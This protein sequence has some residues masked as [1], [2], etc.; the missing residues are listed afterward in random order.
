VPKREITIEQL[1]G[2]I[3]A[4]DAFN[5]LYQF[6]SNVRQLD[7]TPLMDNKG[8]VTS[9]LSGLFYRTT[10][11]MSRGIKMIY[12]FDGISPELKEKTKESREERKEDAREKYNDALKEGSKE[13]MF[14]YSRQNLR[15]NSEMIEESKALIRALGLPVVQAPSEGEAQCAHIVKMSEAYAV[16]SQDYDALAFGG[17]RLIQNL[18]LAKKRRLANGNFVPVSPEMIELED[19]FNSLQINHDQLICLGILIGTDFN[20]GGIKG[21]GPKKALQLVQKYPQP[22]LLFNEVRSLIS[23]GKISDMNFNWQDIFELFK[24][25]NITEDYKLNFS[26][27]DEE[28]VKKILCDEHDFSTERA[29][30]A[31]NK[32]FEQKDKLSQKDLKS[33]F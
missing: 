29:D 11:L 27:I 13:D 28:K 30:S 23:Q 32:I 33:F 8:R 22:V 31:L 19:L 20:P 5:T 6:L 16:A 12:V 25:P 21:I 26:K 14:K 10:N 4:V 9:H 17:S 2:K 24:K 7:G 1:R 3:I 15:L 18:T